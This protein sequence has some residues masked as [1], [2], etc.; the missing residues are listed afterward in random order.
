METM[1]INGCFVLAGTL[2]GGLSTWLITR[3]AK[4]LNELEKAV[5]KMALQIKAY[6]HLEKLYTQEMSKL[7]GIHENTI[8]I[9]NRDKIKNLGFDRPKMTANDVDKLLDDL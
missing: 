6:W 1:I 8:L 9:N 5:S 4:R 3:D 2:L 7:T